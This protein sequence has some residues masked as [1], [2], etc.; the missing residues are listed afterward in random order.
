VHLP[1]NRQSFRQFDDTP[2]PADATA[3]ESDVVSSTPFLDLFL[4]PSD[5]AARSITAKANASFM[6]EP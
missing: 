3:T 2:A 6:V 1:T 4:Q 5:V